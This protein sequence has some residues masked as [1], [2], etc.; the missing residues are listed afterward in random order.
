MG[1]GPLPGSAWRIVAIAGIQLHYYW[2]LFSV[3]CCFKTQGELPL[4]NKYPVSPC[5]QNREIRVLVGGLQLRV[6]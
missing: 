3:N 4:H 2:L 5:C 6:E 1:G